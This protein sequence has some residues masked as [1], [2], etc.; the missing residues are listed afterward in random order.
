MTSGAGIDWA[1]PEIEK[2]DHG[3]VVTIPS[4]R[5]FLTLVTRMEDG[6]S[7]HRRGFFCRGQERDWPLR[8]SL[9]RPAKQTGLSAE[10][11]VELEE[12]LLDEFK[13]RAYGQ[14]PAEFLPTTSV[15]IVNWWMLM[16][17]YGAPTRLLDWTASPF[18][19]AYFAVAQ[20]AAAAT[21]TDEAGVVWMVQAGRL[22]QLTGAAGLSSLPDNLFDQRKVLSD[23]KASPGLTFL[24]RSRLTD[25]MIAQQ[26]YFSISSSPLTDHDELIRQAMAPELAR[27]SPGTQADVTVL[28]LLIPADLKMEFLRRLRAMNITSSALFPG[29]DGLGRSLGELARLTAAHLARG[30]VQTDAE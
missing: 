22:V 9:L 11:F 17:H 28:K 30:I 18:V 16:Q 23:P 26:T 13:E 14:L 24:Q 7:P 4:W 2:S 21:R 15:E 27:L 29:I 6:S 3:L 19:A 1:F 12:R 8:P 5:A 25:R 20:S 10:M